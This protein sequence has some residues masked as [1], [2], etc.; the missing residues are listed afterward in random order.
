MLQGCQ[1]KKSY[2]EGNGANFSSKQGRLKHCFKCNS[3]EYFAL[4][5]TVSRNNVS[6]KIMHYFKGDSTQNFVHDYTGLRNNINTVMESDQVHF[7]LL[8]VDTHYRNIMN[9]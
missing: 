1:R 7:T 8:N 6:C 2:G 9:N 4:D 3:A 5:Y